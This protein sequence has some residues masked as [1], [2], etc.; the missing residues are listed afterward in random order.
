VIVP[1]PDQIPPVE[2]L[3]A[4][5]LVGIGGAALSGLARLMAARGIAVSGCDAHPSPV[6]DELRAAGIPCRVGHSPEHL[7]G[8]DTVVVSTAVPSDTLEVDHARRVGLRLWPRSAAVQSLLLGHRAIV[9]TGTHGKTTTTSML[10]TALLACG[11]DP[12]YAVGSP[13]RA[14]G[15]NAA[16]GSNDLFVTEGDESDAAILVYTPYGA[17]VTNVDADH[18]DFFGTVEAYAEVFERFLA[19][20]DPRG[21]LVCGTDDPGGRR[22]AELSRRSGLR[23]V[24]VGTHPT[25]ALRASDIEPHGPGSR[26]AVTLEGRLLGE[27]T[28]GVPGPSYVFDALAALAAALELGHS[29]DAVLRGLAG[30]RGSARRMEDKGTAAG[31]RVYDSYAH[32][33]TEITA[34]LRAAR[35]LAGRG[36]VVVAFQ[37]HL[38]SRTALFAAEMGAALAGADEVVVTDVYAARE[39]PAPG[40]SGGL[41]ADAVPLPDARVHYVPDLGDVASA[42][43]R[44]ARP[45]DLVLTLGAGD[46][47][48]AGPRVLALLAAEQPASHP[49]TGEPNGP[50]ADDR[51]ADDSDADDPGTADPAAKEP[52]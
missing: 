19:R 22:L 24:T 34:D 33:P 32:H 14:T 47:T 15:S 9:V 12:S 6:L 3:R 49:P 13:L 37:P 28:L 40:V 30:Y 21:F 48:T 44:L 29:A 7:A 35:Q 27:L 36:R 8:V 31:V 10:V 38:F 4:V 45:G 16:V 52:V 11:A 17:V 41:V 5:H 25:A 2:D 39:T 46:V 18:L 51:G 42:L 20:I 23:T 26:C 1:V 50:D 43:T